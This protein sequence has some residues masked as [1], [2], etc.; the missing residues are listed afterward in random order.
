MF[1]Y[2]GSVCRNTRTVFS[3]DVEPL[4]IRKVFTIP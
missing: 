1:S 2:V 4:L 3:K